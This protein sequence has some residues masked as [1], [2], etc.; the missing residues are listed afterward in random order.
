[1]KEKETECAKCGKEEVSAR[2]L[3]SDICEKCYDRV[4]NLLR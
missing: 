3:G 4:T 1:M 2:F